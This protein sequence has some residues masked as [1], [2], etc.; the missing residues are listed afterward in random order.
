MSDKIPDVMAASITLLK[1]DADL[2]ALVDTRVFGDK[3][4]KD[5]AA[6]VPQKLVMVRHAPGVAGMG[7]YID[8]QE[9]VFDVFCYGETPAAAKEVFLEVYRILK[10]ARR[11]VVNETLLHSFE[12]I[13]TP[14][15]FVDLDTSWDGIVCSFRS[16]ASEN[17]VTS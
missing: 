11:Q 8:L 4:P 17:Q 7:G 2:Q 13:S 15:A 12:P 9:T 16:L 10:R 6:A 5:Q 1:Q 14:R 3:V